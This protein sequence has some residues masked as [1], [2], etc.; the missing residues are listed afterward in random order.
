MNW[1]KIRNVVNY[2]K[3]QGLPTDPYG[4]FLSTDSMVDWF[5]LRIRLNEAEIRQIKKELAS[6]IEAELLMVKLQTE[7]I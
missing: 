6:M 4:Q 1:H 2:I 3:K 5:D 7:I